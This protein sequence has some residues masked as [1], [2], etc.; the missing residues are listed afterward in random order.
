MIDHSITVADVFL[1]EG[2][3][4]VRQAEELCLQGFGSRTAGVGSRPS[5]A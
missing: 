5:D 2:H 4:V 3:E 1:H